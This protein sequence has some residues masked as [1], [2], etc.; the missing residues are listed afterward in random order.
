VWWLDEI[1]RFARSC[2]SSETDSKPMVW[3]ENIFERQKSL[4][5][6]R[7]FQVCVGLQA[8]RMS[9]LEMC[10]VLAHMFAPLE[11]TVRFQF[12]WRVVVTVK[13]FKQ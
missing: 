3:L 9:A 4:F 6:A 8:L 1:L 7:A 10:E 2:D 13:N 11:S 5:R 12:V